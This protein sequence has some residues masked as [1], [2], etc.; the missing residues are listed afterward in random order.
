MNKFLDSALSYV[1]RG[2][3]V[4][5][6]Q[7]RSK[8]P[9]SK[10]YL[11]DGNGNG[12]VKLATTDAA[13]IRAWWDR[14]PDANVGIS[15]TAFAVLDVD[16]RHEGD[17]HLAKLIT[18]HGDLPRTVEAITGGGGWHFLFQQPATK[19]RN[20]KTKGALEFRGEGGYILA[21]PSVHPDGG[22]YQWEASCHPDDGTPIAPMPNWLRDLATKKATNGKAAPVD[23]AIPEGERHT[24]LLSLA[25]TVRRRGMDESEI[26]ALLTTVN[27]RRCDPPMTAAELKSIAQGVA[28]Y[29][30]SD[31]I[32][33]KG[34]ALASSG[35]RATP[36]RQT[37][38]TFNELLVTEFPEP[39]WAIPAILPV[40]LVQLGGRPKVGKSWLAL[41]WAHAIGAGGRTLDQNVEQGK[42]LYLGLEDSGRRIK[43]RLIKQLAVDGCDAVLETRWPNLADGGL[44]DL[45]EEIG[46]E[47]YR[48]VVIDTIARI[49]GETDPD[50]N[51]LMTPL[52]SNL[53]AITILHDMT[54]LL[55]DHHKKP[56]GMGVSVI[57]DIIGS[58]AKSAVADSVMGLYKEQGKRGATL[59]ITGRDIEEKDLALEWDGL[60]C[61]WQLLG[62]AGQVM[63]DTV[64][65]AILDGIADLLSIGELATPTAIS[66]HIDKERAH[67][68]RGLTSLIDRGDVIR[69]P[70]AGRVQPY[71]LPRKA[72]SKG[73]V[74]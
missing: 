28:R 1:E 71:G 58:T 7:S 50:K 74:V 31:P 53:Q 27:E 23:N 10:K 20:S 55:I 36:D 18:E 52:L 8:V 46:R 24:T 67:V 64:E 35:S 47:K 19:I 44:A 68:S 6:L 17:L 33:A 61:S 37:R 66:E 57:D 25:G 54:I 45:Q 12:G 3:P 60:T 70:K 30:A 63:K 42:V 16:P 21:P 22:D 9:I 29:K 32:E 43:T 48:L 49:M 26:L 34:P 11:S 59:R 39:T 5:P 73:R 14:W 62:E 38:W 51:H 2:W 4:F 56:S 69:L 65:S 13:T 72:P 40:G 41:Q 15:T